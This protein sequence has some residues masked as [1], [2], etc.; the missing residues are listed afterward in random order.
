ME[1]LTKAAVSEICELVDDS[2]A[3]LQLEI[4]RSHK[5]NEALR[6]RLELI[7][8]IIARGQRGT[9]AMLDDGRMEAAGGGFM[10]FTLGEF[11]GLFQIEPTCKCPLL[12]C[13]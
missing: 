11:R 8:T 13:S 4:S 10:G 9:V 6:R 2:Y 12:P 1:A 7:E 5:E 3:V